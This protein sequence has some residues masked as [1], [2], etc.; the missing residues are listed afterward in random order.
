MKGCPWKWFNHHYD[1]L[2]SSPNRL[3]VMTYGFGNIMG[4]FQVQLRYEHMLK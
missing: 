3:Y 2:V 1:L 4:N